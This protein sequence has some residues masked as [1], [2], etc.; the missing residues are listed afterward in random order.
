MSGVISIGVVSMGGSGASGCM[1]GIVGS[2][3]MASISRLQG[4]LGSNG[5][6]ALRPKCC[7]TSMVSLQLKESLMASNTVW[8]CPCRRP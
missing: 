8:G 4:A 3:W 6:S 2:D 5:T 7:N 1:E